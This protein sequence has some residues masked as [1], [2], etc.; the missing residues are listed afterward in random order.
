MEHLSDWVPFDDPHNADQFKRADIVFGPDM[1][2]PRINNNDR[3][4]TDAI[5]EGRTAFTAA[6][7]SKTTAEMYGADLSDV[8]LREAVRADIHSIRP[9][10]E[11]V[12]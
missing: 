11:S 1:F 3:P 12:D 5:M 2:D 8:E 6:D 10:E 4:F 9:R 7:M